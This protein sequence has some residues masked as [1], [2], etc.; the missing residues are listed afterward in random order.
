ME[1]FKAIPEYKI[2]PGEQISLKLFYVLD[3]RTFQRNC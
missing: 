2:F 1:L 3:F